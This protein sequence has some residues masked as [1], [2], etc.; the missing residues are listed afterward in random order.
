MKKA[1]VIILLAAAPMLLYG[2]TTGK[3]AGRVIDQATGQPLP[4]ASISIEGAKF[5]AASNT[6]GFYDIINI[7][8]GDYT[9]IVQFVGYTKTRIEN[10]RV[11]V[12]R[13]T[14]LDV[15]LSE[16]SVSLGE[17]VIRAERPAVQK[18]RTYTASVVNAESINLMPV[19]SVQEIIQLQ[20]GVVSS[21]GELH[22]RGGRGREVAYLI[23]GVPVTNAFNQGGGNNV[24][25]ENSM[26]QELE[27]ISGTFN[28]EYGAAQSGIVN[29]ITKGPSPKFTGTAKAYAGEW[30]SSRDDIFLGIKD[31]NPLA[32]KDVQLSLSGPIIPEKLGFSVSGR[33]NKSE[34][35]LWYEKRYTALDGWRIA[36]YQKWYQGAHQGESSSESGIYVPDSLK[37]GDR[38][39]GPLSN[40]DNATASLKLDFFPVSK[41]KL[42]YQLFG[43]YGW[44]RSGDASRRYQP[45]QLAQNRSWS[46]HHFLSFKHAPADNFFYN[47]NISYQWNDGESYYRKDNK[48]AQFPGDDGIQLISS[49]ADGFSLGDTDGFYT[50]ADDKNY[51]RLIL[52]N[53]DLNWQIDRHNF[54]K[55]GFEIKKHTINTYSWNY[56]ATEEWK[57]KMWPTEDEI[58]PSSYS[59]NEYWSLLSDYWKTWDETFGAAKYRKAHADE[60]TLWRDYTIKPW[61]LA[62]Y[63]QDKLELGEIIVNA[64]LRL[65]IFVPN[66]KV[67]VNYR[68]ESYN[69]GAWSNL[70]EAER[71]FQ[72]SPRLG[73]SFPLSPTGVFHAAYGHFF[74]MPSFEKMFNQPLRTLTPLQLEGMLLGN[75]ELKPEKTIAYEIGLQQGITG[76]IAIDVTAY[77][78]DI[79]NLLGI[80]KIITVDAIGYTRFINRDYGNSRGVTIGLRKEG[81]GFIT[82]AIN[83]TYSDSRGSSSDP[84]SLALIESSTSIGGAP[85]QFV[86]RQIL[87]L[88]WDQR[89]TLN[90][91]LNF[92]KQGNWNLGLIGYMRSGTPYSPSFVER[93]DLSEIEYKNSGTKPFNWNLDLIAKKFFKLG[94]LNTAL[95]VKVDNVFDNLNEEY[96]YSSTGRAG[97]NARLPQEEELE[98]ERLAQ[99]NNFTLGEIDNHPEWYSSP[100]K[101][102][103]GFEVLF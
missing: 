70:K 56:I 21:G 92:S 97:Q 40:Y 54:I 63:I 31:I 79:R 69:I 47:I 61:E 2:G 51:R 67:P 76:D 9:V 17:V 87:P 71:Q 44:S 101:V 75:A 11:E 8:P 46:H 32:E 25:V 85:V 50:D 103:F 102:E 72:L 20:P 59:F 1:F 19:T 57:A 16:E 42:I 98:K 89:H 65:D 4:G 96:V 48:I 23:D 34:S 6:D 77:Y 43:S 62:G 88:D 73:V 100:R 27:V 28:A 39:Q 45:D 18:D 15:P 86:D 91:I 22:F 36:A 5:G 49:S 64:G 24:A 7:S 29:I 37:S 82:G 3:I 13:T 90:V 93:Y 30:Y 94:G 38:S 95:F 41:V 26:I 78:K 81:N 80:E 52:L 14:K 58:N 83:Y 84:E 66:E 35:Y 53:G 60:A 12:D 68:V 10:V 55:A 74:Q 33:Y 99:E